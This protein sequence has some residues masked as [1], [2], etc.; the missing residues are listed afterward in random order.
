MV[1]AARKT[2]K[3]EASLVKSSS[4][5]YASDI[6]LCRYE[7]LNHR[8]GEAV[9][10]EFRINA[11]LQKASVTVLQRTE[12]PKDLIQQHR[13]NQ[14]TY[15]DNIY[16]L[17]RPKRVKV[18]PAEPV[19]EQPTE[20]AQEAQELAQLLGAYVQ[21]ISDKMERFEEGIE[22]RLNELREQCQTLDTKLKC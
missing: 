4:A 19:A 21:Q 12:M 2:L 13:F 22:G 17:R 16:S 20:E 14:A 10:C 1:K 3:V 11:T 9:K 15:E 6:P 18:A 8:K 7:V 5:P